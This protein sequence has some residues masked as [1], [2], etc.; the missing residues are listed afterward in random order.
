[1]FNPHKL[2]LLPALAALGGSNNTMVTSA[3][4]GVQVPLLT[5]Q[6]NTFVPY[7][8]PDTVAFAALMLLNEP[9]PDTT[10]QAPVPTVGVL[11]ARFAVV[12]AFN[13]HKFWFNPAFAVVGGSNK[14]IVTSAVEGAQVAPLVIVQRKTFGPY[15][16][17]DTVVVD[18]A[19]LPKLPDPDTTVQAPVPTVGVFAARFTV[20]TVFNPHNCWLAPAFAV[21]GKASTLIVTKSSEL[22][23]PLVTVHFNM[24]GV[25]ILNPVTVAFGLFACAAA[26]VPGPETIVQAPVPKVGAFADNVAVVT[27]HNVWSVP[28]FATV[29]KASTIMSTVLLELVQT[30]L[31]ITH[32]KRVVLP[33]VKPVT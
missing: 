25:V 2:W 6:R 14:V 31:L 20:V 4:E 17:P 12:V 13:P 22:Q 26:T 29:G 9:V 16:K 5:V 27:L 33:A 24:V 19:A 18:T 8:K 32:W 10:D 30:P 1:V 28:A 11:A 21:V 3:V 7:D 23:V 15:D